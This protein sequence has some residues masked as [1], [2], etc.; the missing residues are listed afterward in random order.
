MEPY[1]S[2]NLGVSVIR[3]PSHQMESEFF[4]I[5]KKKGFS[6]DKAKICA[7]IF[8]ENSLDGVY[9]HGVN[10]FSRFV[11][12]V[13]KG[14]IRINNQPELKNRS[15]AIEQWDG[16][17]GPG[18]INALICTEQ[19]MHLSKEYGIG[20]VAL[21]NTNHWM[22]GGAYGWKAAKAG[23]VFIG[24]T[25][26]IPNMPAWGA[27]D[28]R[29]GNNPLVL[30]VPY[31]DE[32]I[33]LDMAMS[34]FSYG[35]MESYQ[36]QNRQL[37][38]PGGYNKK[39]QLT[40]DPG[41]ILESQRSLPVGYWKGAGLS[42]LLNLMAAIL[43]GGEATHRIRQHEDDFGVSQVY[44][45]IDISKLDNFQRIVQDVKEI[46]DDYHHS[47]PES[48]K[49]SIIYPGERALRTRKENLLKGI[50]V[51]RVVWDRIKGL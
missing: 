44:I 18:P 39:G 22:R 4:R 47:I 19:A 29:L 8:T 32:A 23:F 20:C 38:L 7:G 17:L 41:E 30:A 40:T 34:Q 2:E 3:I 1:K 9:S 15:G 24:W 43:S 16:K 25:N 26:T 46:I 33:V 31:N 11:E 5:L 50:P 48:K 49:C 51:D 13:D 35:T 37:P 42:L 10:R 28:C 36:L 12:F 14:Y 45:S 6:S 27:V 21:S